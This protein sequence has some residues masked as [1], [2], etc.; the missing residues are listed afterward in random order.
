MRWLTFNKI[1]LALLLVAVVSVLGNP[2]PFTDR[3]RAQLQRLFAPVSYPVRLAAGA[4]FRR[5][6]PSPPDVESPTGAPRTYQDVV[7]E[8]R[9][10][11]LEIAHLTEQLH[12]LEQINADREALGS[13]RDLCRP[14]RVVGSDTGL[15]KSIS[16][17]G[18]V[19]G[20]KTGMAVLCPNG[21]AGKVDRVGWSGGAQAQLVTDGAF[22]VLA[23]FG[24]LEHSGDQATFRVLSEKAVLLEGDGKQGMIARSVAAKDVESSGIRAGD[25]AMIADDDY[26]TIV[27]GY[28]IGQVSGVKPSK[29]PQFV[30]VTISLLQ[31]PLK[32]REAMVLVR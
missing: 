20:I 7:N 25:W 27:Q 4:A 18:D 12:R 29:T 11:R 16:L 28:R 1:Y 14:M 24:R 30:D 23:R 15:R 9:E 26:P 22:R 10:L 2:K 31:D 19:N 17:Q 13:L 8:N 32:L 21:L 3:G 6:N 5:L